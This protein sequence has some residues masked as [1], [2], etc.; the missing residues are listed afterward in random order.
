MPLTDKCTI[1]GGPFTAE[2]GQKAV[3]HKIYE[4]QPDKAWKTVLYIAWCGTC[5]ERMDEWM[6]T[7]T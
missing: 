7:H 4:I 1:C 2:P 3:E 5:I 6:G